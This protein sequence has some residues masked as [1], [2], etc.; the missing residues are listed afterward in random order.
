MFS[1]KILAIWGTTIIAGAIAGALLIKN[2]TA[3]ERISEESL[4]QKYEQLLKNIEKQSGKECENIKEFSDQ[5]KQ[6]EREFDI[7]RQQKHDLIAEMEVEEYI[8]PIPGSEAPE[9]SE[10]PDIQESNEY[11]PRV[12]E[13]Q[14]DFDGNIVVQNDEPE[15]YIP[16][17][18][19]SEVPE[20][21]EMPD[22][23]ESNEYI[24]PIPGSEPL[25]F[26]MGR[27]TTIQQINNKE[28]DIKDMLDALAWKCEEKETN[29]CKVACNN[30]TNKCLSL[31]PNA[32]KSLID[33]GFSSCVQECKK[34]D[35]TKIQCMESA[36]DCVAMTEICG[37]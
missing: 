15:E 7:L 17:I 18:P 12:G 13:H 14:L 5:T 29:N 2:N 36:K 4:L 9:L 31:V 32:N 24:P 37:L 27:I 1:R 20:L 34:W 26:D 23:Q 28:V 16:P 22:I 25:D 35:K 19:G 33:Q 3:P 11:I 10:M 21:S 30:Y 8:P 6:L